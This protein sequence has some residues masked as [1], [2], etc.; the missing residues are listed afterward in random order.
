M[1]SYVI[2]PA[3]RLKIQ[4]ARDEGRTLTEIAAGAQTHQSRISELLGGRSVGPN[5]VDGVRRLAA[6]VGVA[7][8]E[9]VIELASE[10]VPTSQRSATL[11]AL[12]ETHARGEDTLPAWCSFAA[13]VLVGA[14]ADPA[15]TRQPAFKRTAVSLYEFAKHACKIRE[16]KNGDIQIRAECRDLYSGLWQALHHGAGQVDREY[17]LKVARKALGGGAS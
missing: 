12:Y 6:A 17:F 7:P 15:M 3:L 11:V 9:A 14:V 4:Q 5:A 2:S 13:H 8:S 1:K 16:L 10:A